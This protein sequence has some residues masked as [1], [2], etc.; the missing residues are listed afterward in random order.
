MWAC[1]WSLAEFWRFPL[2][3]FA[4]DWGSLLRAKFEARE[5]II[6]LQM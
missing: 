4:G 5:K 1:P 2:E 6:M 3:R